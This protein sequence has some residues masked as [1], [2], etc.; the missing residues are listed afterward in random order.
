MRHR[1]HLWLYLGGSIA[2][3]AATLGVLSYYRRARV[4]RAESAEEASPEAGLSP[5]ETQRLSP[6]LSDELPPALAEALAASARSH[7]LTRPVSEELAFQIASQAEA[8]RP[9]SGDRRHEVSSL[10]TPMALA[11][12]ADAMGEELVD[13]GAIEIPLG[14]SAEERIDGLLSRA[15]LPQP[16]STGASLWKQEEAP[17]VHQTEVSISGRSSSDDAITARTAQEPAPDE[18]SYDAL[19]PD[20]LGTEWLSRAT[21]SISGDPNGAELGTEASPPEILLEEGMSIVSEGSLNA[22]SA[23]GIESAVIA[24]LD[25]RDEAEDSLDDVREFDDPALENEA[26]ARRI[27]RRNT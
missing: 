1:R 24:Q 16:D 26:R 20:D 15:K 4:P 3:G 13:P 12:D 2:F 17:G 23:E 22:A 14:Q 18:E 21:E 25:E 5:A 11:P 8:R 7:G 10:A 9:I 27:H 6:G 19:A